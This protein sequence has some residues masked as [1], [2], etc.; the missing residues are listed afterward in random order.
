V[1]GEG[2]EHSP[3]YLGEYSSTH[4][5]QSISSGAQVGTATSEQ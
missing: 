4:V 3:P 1:T 2:D 5:V